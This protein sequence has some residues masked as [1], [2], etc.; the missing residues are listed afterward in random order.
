M[1][2]QHD[3]QLDHRF[4]LEFL[5]ADAIQDVGLRARRCRELNDRAG[6]HPRLH[7][8]GQPGNRVMGFVH[9]HEGAVHVQQVGEGDLHLPACQSFQARQ[10]LGQAAEVR[11]QVLMV[12]VDPAPLR[13]LGA[14]SLDGADNQAAVAAEVMGADVREVGNV[15]DPDTP[16]KGVVQRLP[17]GM[18]RI[19][20]RL[21]GL[22]PY[23]VGRR[24]PER[25]RVV[26]FH[27]GIAGNA[28]CMGAE[29]GLAAAGWQAQADIGHLRQLL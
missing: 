9:N 11:L 17:V 29:E 4:L 10:V 26:L 2:R 3:R 18:G 6:V 21:N 23:G 13:A 20:Q 5:R 7:F 8:P 24:Q 28:H 12:R 27:P 1:L 25:H 14:Q 16:L 19:L 22:L 15:E